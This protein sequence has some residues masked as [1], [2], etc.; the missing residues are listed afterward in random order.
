M[1]T[2]SSSATRQMEL[3]SNSWIFAV[4]EG[5]IPHHFDDLEPA[6]LVEGALQD[7]GE[8]VK[9]D[10]IAVALLG[11][12]DQASGRGV[13]EPEALFKHRFQASSLG[14]VQVAVGGGDMHQQR[15]GGEPVIFLIE[16]FFGG[17]GAA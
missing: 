6:I 11:L 5:D 8:L 12:F 4:G 7:A 16:G 15:G 3:S 13:V 17:L 1:E 2:P 10:R 9:A 14:P